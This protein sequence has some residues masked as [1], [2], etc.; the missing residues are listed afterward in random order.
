MKRSR[1]PQLTDPVV[2]RRR[3]ALSE[4]ER[5]LWELVAKQVK[6]LR[7]KRVVKPEPVEDAPA[8][9]KV[10][11]PKRT[12]SAPPMAVKP[13]KPAPPPVP[14]LA[15]LGRRERSQLSRGRKEIDARIDLHGMTQTRAH[16]ALSAF[17]HRAS[18]EGLTF[19]LV[20][21]GKGRTVG[22]EAERGILRRQ[23]PLWLGLPEFRSLVVGFEEAHIGHGGA[24]ALYVRIRRA[25]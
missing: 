10:A 20:I 12:A 23:V 5:E 3:R 21:T 1:P 14:P 7:K 11:A 18:H 19:V 25:R 15:P 6:P 9:V 24:G 2:S 13:A 17:L 16:H 8:L 22:P 4:E